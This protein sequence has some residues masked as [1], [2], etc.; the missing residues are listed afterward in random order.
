MGTDSQLKLALK[1]QSVLCYVSGYALH[2]CVYEMHLTN[3]A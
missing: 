1:M 2:M 3:A